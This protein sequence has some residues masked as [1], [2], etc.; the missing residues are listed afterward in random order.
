M[1][2][3]LDESGSLNAYKKGFFSITMVIIN[4]SK[5]FKKL[6]NYFKRQIKKLKKENGIP[7]KIEI[8]GHFLRQN[9]MIKKGEEIFNSIKEKFSIFT[10]YFDNNDINKKFLKKKNIAFNYMLRYGI[11]NLIWNKTI[12]E[13]EKNIKLYCDQR[14]IK[15]SSFNSLKE[16]LFD[17]F[18]LEKDY[19][20]NFE[21]V[22][23]FDSK[24]NWFIQLADICSFYNSKAIKN[25]TLRNQRNVKKIEC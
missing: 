9:D 25:V 3:L 4:T 16:C 22:R 1:F 11:K 7:E 14:S 23:Y 15:T 8:K 12:K 21:E 24:N 10:F 13:N 17:Y 2:I 20:L 6:K 19:D 5:E 18:I